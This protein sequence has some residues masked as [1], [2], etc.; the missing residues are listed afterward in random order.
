MYYLQKQY[1]QIVLP[2]KIM[3]LSLMAMFSIQTLYTSQS[4]AH[5]SVSAKEVVTPKP[6]TDPFVQEYVKPKPKFLSIVDTNEKIIHN[7]TDIFCM[8]KNIYHEAA[9][10]S[11]LGK[12]AVAQVTVNRMKD[13][14]FESGIC[15]VVLEPY[16]FSWANDR[17][18]RWTTP[19]GPKW[20]E[21]KRIAEEVLVQ[22]KR[23]HGMQTAL[24]YHADYV[25]PRWA[26]VKQKI[27]KIGAHIFYTPRLS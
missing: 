24:F 14:R 6:A 7:K 22:G 26:R 10:E 12:Y 13:P 19:Q 1:N 11:K 5:A 8:A 16:Q 21:S 17:R 3:V 23:I 27:V 18:I 15:E 25:S 20:E 9:L 2:W 4:R